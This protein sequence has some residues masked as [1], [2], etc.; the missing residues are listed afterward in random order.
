VN[1]AL[2]AANAKCTMQNEESKK[3]GSEPSSFW[4]CHFALC[5]LHFSFVPSHRDG[6]TAAL[7]WHVIG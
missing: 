3:S 1:A 4:I 6:V 2:R 5:I 7:S